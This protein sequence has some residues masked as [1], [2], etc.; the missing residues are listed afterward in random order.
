MTEIERDTIVVGLGAWGSAALW[1]LAARGIDV[2]GIERYGIGHPLGSTHGTTRLFRI[3]CQEHPG[4]PPIALTSLRLWR[5]LGE[6]TGEVYVRQTG[7]LGVGSPTSTPVAGAIAAARSAGVPLERLSHE[8]LA[9][10]FPTYGG[11]A[12]DEVAVIDPQAGIC[13]PERFVRGH[14]AAARRLG[15]DVY[16][17]T[18]VTAIEPGT[19]RI[20]LRT[21]T[22]DFLARRIVLALG[23]WLV[24]YVP[25]LPLQPRRT[26]MYWF[27]PRQDATGAYDLA[28]FPGFI[29]ALPDG[30]LLWG[31]GS[32]EGFDIKIGPGDEAGFF[33]DTDAD[34]VDR[35]VHQDTDIAPLSRLVERAFPG[36]DPQPAK[37][38]PCMVTNS[39]DGQFLVGPLI[40][41]PRIVV[42]G[43]DSG[44]GAKHAA[45]LGELIARLVVGEEPYTPI[46]FLDPN[47]F[48]TAPAGLPSR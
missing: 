24:K 41:D 17:H 33:R 46:G 42:A 26:P 1:R 16:P 40:S 19:D 7:F 38:I 28:H 5:E 47:R 27:R 6:E 31:H 8:E 18:M 43:G 35:Y 4:L 2:A 45:G 11:L 48:A 44:H 10:R 9:A 21:P 13:Y 34:E 37:V 36:L 20:R 22:V 32:A 39:P 14:V 3:A 25:E 30:T 12:G 29:R 15:A 23:A